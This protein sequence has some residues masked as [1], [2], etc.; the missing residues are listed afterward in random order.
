MFKISNTNLNIKLALPC[1]LL[2]SKV[3]LWMVDL[4]ETIKMCNAIKMNEI[5]FYYHHEHISLKK[6]TICIYPFFKI[7]SH[8]NAYII[9]NVTCFLLVCLSVC[10]F[11]CFF[12][13]FFIFFKGGVGFAKDCRQIPN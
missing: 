4:V 7:I 10:L 6:K 9:Y 1:K 13:Y 3:K 5:T 2:N 8:S 12:I 11:D